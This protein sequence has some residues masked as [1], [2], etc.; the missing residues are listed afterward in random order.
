MILGA[1]I[2]DLGKWHEALICICKST[3]VVS[4]A[5][6]VTNS[7]MTSTTKKVAA[8]SMWIL[9][10]ICAALFPTHGADIQVGFAA[11][12]I[13]PEILVGLGRTT[14]VTV[15]VSDTYILRNGEGATFDLPEGSQVSLDLIGGNLKCAVTV[16]GDPVYEGETSNS[17]FIMSTSGKGF[18]TI[19]KDKS[20]GSQLLG[21]SYWGDAVLLRD[22]EDL[23]V[24]NLIELEKYLWSVVSCEIPNS[25]N[26]ETLKAQAVASRTYA[27]SQM[28]SPTGSQLGFDRGFIES[29]LL[30]Q[31]V[32][33]WAASTDQEYKGRTYEDLRVVAACLETKGEVLTYGGELIQAYFHADAAGMTEEPRF[34]WGGSVPYYAAVAEIEHSSPHSS[35]EVSYDAGLL[36]QRL[37]EK[38]LTGSP[39]VILGLEPG[40]SG[41]WSLLDVRSANGD[42]RLKPTEFRSI[43]QLK[44]TWFSVFRQG[45]NL[46]T[47]GCLNPTLDIYVCNGNAVCRTS[48]ASCKAVGG[49]VSSSTGVERGALA[50]SVSKDGP[51]TF[52][53]K[54]KG[55]G[56]GVGLSQWG[57][58]EMAKCGSD[59][60]DILMHYYPGTSMERW[61]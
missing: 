42:L 27:L 18:F 23:I 30:P 10:I 6:E 31:H 52:T 22:S 13:E 34:V 8:M 58:N 21:R 40:V 36:A 14:G 17:V 19:V 46:P 51:V 12:Q 25:W 53:F 48:L 5:W 20:P 2:F 32:K 43:L 56:H 38:G 37:N 29:S 49:E 60:C 57:A 9:C 11:A 61:W 7:Q 39:S 3:V 16:N 28:G 26:V 1:V 59:Y 45:G 4:L 47:L 35:W 41:R 50:M 54:G 15:S 33:I 44:S 24:A 55:S